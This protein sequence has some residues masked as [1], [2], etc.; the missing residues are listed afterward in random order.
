MK[1]VLAHNHGHKNI[2]DDA[3]AINVFRT[4]E[5]IDPQIMTISTY[6]PPVGQDASRDVLSLTG[7]IND[8][9]SPLRKIFLVACARLRLRWVYALFVRTYCAWA[10]TASRIHQHPV[11]GLLVS[12]RMRALIRVLADTDLYVRSGS[13]S[14][15]DIWFWSSMWPQLTE[16]R[17]ARS[18]GARVAFTG[19][20]LGP[21][22]GE[23]RLQA[24]KAL[25]NT[26]DYMSFRDAS[27]S[28]QLVERVAGPAG[29]CV[30]VGDDAFDYACDATPR[31]SSILA[32]CRRG[33]APLIVCQ[34]RATDYE[35]AIADSFWA[36][37]QAQFEQVVK[38]HPDVRILF[39]S[40]STGRVNDLV[41][42]RRIATGRLAG[43]VTL[44]E[45]NLTPGE[46]RALISAAMLTIGQSYHFG[47]FSLAEN[48][49]F[50]GLYTNEYYRAKLGGLLEWYGLQHL[51]L[52]PQALDSLATRVDE[53]LTAEPAM[54]ERL[55][56]V[57]DGIR[58]RL[59]QQW[60]KIQC[61]ART[62]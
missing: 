45:D 18:M 4:L 8:Y 14:L 9:R 12:S 23:Y 20:G 34:F 6:S 33:D 36:V 22:T 5:A 42:A 26:V 1:T 28:R 32:T 54:V 15:N 7:I 56:L 39:L 38:R 10:V 55:T 51:A 17:I 61:L 53:V 37:L 58:D 59:D 21:L 3:M 49:P 11:I 47:V 60:A 13:G 31:V 27:E 2:G 52:S 29:H 43:A 35:K 24:L 19:Q 48:V 41:P 50:I 25:V 46:A 16:A 40:F 62:A 44:V 57:N 30:T